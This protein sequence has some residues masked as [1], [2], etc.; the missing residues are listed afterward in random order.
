MIYLNV[1]STRI[2]VTICYDVRL[3][4]IFD[5]VEATLERVPSASISLYVQHRARCVNTCRAPE[6]RTKATKTLD[7]KR[8]RRALNLFTH[9]RFDPARSDTVRCGPVWSGVVRCNPT[10]FGVIWSSPVRSDTVR[11]RTDM[12]IQGFKRKPTEGNRVNGGIAVLSK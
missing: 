3:T 6:R 11:N 2:I 4:A 7:D 9:S 5:G 1:N 12:C 10:R 8:E